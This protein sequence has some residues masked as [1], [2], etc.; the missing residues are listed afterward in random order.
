MYDF[1]FGGS[2]S[3]QKKCVQYSFSSLFALAAS[4]PYFSGVYTRLT[5]YIY[6]NL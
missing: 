6:L 5:F 3:T 1:V 2:N 4:I